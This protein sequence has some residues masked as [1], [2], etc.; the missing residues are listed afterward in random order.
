MFR[1]FCIGAVVGFFFG[2]SRQGINLRHRLESSVAGVLDGA[3]CNL[4][5]DGDHKNS[6]SNGDSAWSR[7]SLPKIGGIKSDG[8]GGDKRVRLEAGSKQGQTKEQYSNQQSS[9]KASRQKN[10]LQSEQEPLQSSTEKQAPQRVRSHSDE[11]HGISV[12]KAVELAQSL[13]TKPVVP[14]T[15]EAKPGEHPTPTE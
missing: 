5:E 15:E 8:N 2:S 7:S 1:S 11:E 9:A 10:D 14:P 3:L 12:D 4:L 6:Q 13:S